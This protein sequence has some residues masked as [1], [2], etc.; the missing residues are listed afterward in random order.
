MWPKKSA[1]VLMPRWRCV[2]GSNGKEGE[3][4]CTVWQEPS[5]MRIDDHVYT[6]ARAHA[7][8]RRQAGR[9]AGR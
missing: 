7:R 2:Y 5:Y 1:F 4:A 9:Q 6:R 3:E 8:T